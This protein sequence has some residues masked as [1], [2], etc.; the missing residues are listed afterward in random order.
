MPLFG[1]PPKRKVSETRPSSATTSSSKSPSHDQ[2]SPPLP[3]HSPQ[4][5]HQHLVPCP[6]ATQPYL[7]PQQ[8]SWQVAVPRQYATNPAAASSPYLPLSPPQSPPVYQ[9]W[10]AVQQQ[11]FASSS[12]L[13]AV[14]NCP[15]VSRTVEYLN[16]GAAV[17][18]M[19]GDRQS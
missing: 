6:Y 4:L 14:T 8:P 3:Y 13:P 19:I 15:V 17:C 2:R 10:P 9:S 7:L 5:S 12:N 18:D 11:R 1:K 16:R